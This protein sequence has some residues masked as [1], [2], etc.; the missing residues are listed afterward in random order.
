L[1]ARRKFL[2]GELGGKDPKWRYIT[3]AWFIFL[4]VVYL[5]F[6]GLKSYNAI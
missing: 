6:S 1:V 4:W 2:G 3:A 5:A